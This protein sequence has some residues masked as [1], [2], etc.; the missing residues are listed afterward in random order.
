M[1]ILYLLLYYFCLI[2]HY[3]Q[4]VNYL[5]IICLTGL[6]CVMFMFQVSDTSLSIAHSPLTIFFR[7][8]S[9]DDIHVVFRDDTQRKRYV[10]LSERP[11][12]PTI[13]PD[14]NFLEALG[15]EG[16]VRY[17]CHQLQWEEYFDAINVTYRHLTLEF[18]SSLTYEP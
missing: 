3:F 4:K 13:Y 6:T 16:S 9:F 11:L 14:P 12:L 15:L 2:F 1:T 7:M 17:L 18:I 5:I 10:V 8:P